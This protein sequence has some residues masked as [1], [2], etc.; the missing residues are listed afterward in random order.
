MVFID[1]V[2]ENRIV[3]KRRILKCMA[4]NATTIEAATGE[5]A[6]EMCEKE[7]ERFDV[8]IVYQYMEEA[9]GVM[10]GTAVV[11]A[12]RRMLIDATIIGCSC[13]NLKVEFKEAGADSVWQKPMPSNADIIRLWRSSCSELAQ[14]TMS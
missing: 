9:G 5:E 12:M 4:P 7:Q 11:F 3:L 13:N 8:I 6:L 1:D 10:L 14:N 2:K